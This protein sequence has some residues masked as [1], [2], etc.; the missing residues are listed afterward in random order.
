MSSTSL[1]ATRLPRAFAPLRHPVFRTL[2]LATLASNT[3]MWVQNTG[4]GWLMTSLDPSP[5]M[6][7][8]VQAASMLP[9]F[10]L[11]LPAGAL[12]DI[13]DRRRFLIGAQLWMLLMAI[14]LAVLAATDA[15]G[16]WGLLAITF[17]IGAGTAIN[18]PAWAATTPE[19]VPREDLVGAV[20][21][22]GIG[23]NL[24]RALGPA[25]G[26]FA[27]AAAGPE[28]AFALNAFA[29]LLLI[30][31]LVA[32]R[33]PASTRSTLPK[34]HLIG[35]MGAGLRF[36]AASP[37]MQ[38][39]TLRA[40][41]FFLPAAAVWGLLP[42][43]VRGKL[44]LGPEAFGL[45]LGVMGVSAVGAGFILPAIRAR[46]DRGTLVFRA[47]L[48]VALAMGLLA[49]AEHWLPAALAMAL[50]GAA[51][52][53][54]GST[55]AVS[56]QTA[57][58][59]WVRA[60]AI[61]IYQ[62]SFFGMMAFGAAL[63]GWLGARFGVAPALAAASVG[64]IALSLLVR[65]WRLDPAATPAAREGDTPAAVPMPEAPAAELEKLLGERSG[66]V[67]EVVRYCID[68]VDRA[69][70]LDA[71][72]EV[73]RVRLRSGALTWR[74]YEDVAH[75]ERWAEFWAVENWTEHLREANRLTENDVEALA[76]AAALHRADAPPEASRYLNVPP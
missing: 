76:R 61:A 57:A 17:G 1:P 26:G 27:I 41:A 52:I 72:Q 22:N 63:A 54:A 73:R 55:L 7:S 47:S 43:Y 42:L 59:A 74:L 23:F 30:V 68:P 24:A 32:W 69:A 35:A 20:A 2:W 18:F 3:G 28:A 75:P 31:A 46:L 48:L 62:L 10:L 44:G 9:V 45:M 38:A 33:R 40:C 49:L 67:L 66:R 13:V 11:A 19:L 6:V 39:A 58:P 70:F 15:L 56:A 21:L 8:M 65:P 64:G 50:Y 14:L 25:L 51:W 71:M 36:V 16:P 5:F 60:R 37:A 4:A 34:E 53:A 29:F 12:A